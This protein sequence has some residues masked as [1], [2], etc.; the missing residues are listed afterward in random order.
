VSGAVTIRLPWPPSVNTYWRSVGRGRVLISERGRD[1][2]IAVALA[3]RERWPGL[4]HPTRARLVVSIYAWPPDRRS[5]DLDNL[6]KA[7]FDALTHAGVWQDDSQ[8]DGLAVTRLAVTKGGFID[9]GIE[10]V[11]GPLFHRGWRVAE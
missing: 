11:N 10:G 3:V 6:P 8:I 5:R 9:V 1:Y 2:R 7:V 4:R